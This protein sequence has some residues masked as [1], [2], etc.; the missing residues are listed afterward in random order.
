MRLPVALVFYSHRHAL[1]PALQICNDIVYFFS[2]LLLIL[3]LN[4]QLGGE[5]R[6]HIQ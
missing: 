6:G 4:L 3:D 2:C 5:N 1:L